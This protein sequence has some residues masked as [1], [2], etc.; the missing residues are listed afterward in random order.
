MKH[1]RVLS[2]PLQKLL[3]DLKK[4]C[5]DADKLVVAYM[6]GKRKNDRTNK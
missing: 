2:K 4:V 6:N 5:D 1:K 3:W